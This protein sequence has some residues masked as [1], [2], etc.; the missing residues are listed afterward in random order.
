MSKISKYLSFVKF[1]H[2]V[3]ALPF[4]LVGASVG[5]ITTENSFDYW[6]ILFIVLCMVFARNAAMGF[7]RYVDRYFDSKNPRT[8]QREIPSGKITLKDAKIFI[9]LNCILFIISAL[10]INKMC[11]L[12]S[13]IALIVI[14]GYSITKRFTYLCHFVLGIGLGLAPLGAYIAIM[15]QFELLP[16]LL[17]LAVLFWVSGFDIIYALQDEEFDKANDLH[18]IPAK[19]GKKIGLRISRVSHIFSA[20]FMFLFIGL[21]ISNFVVEM[22]QGMVAFLIFVGSLIYQ[23]SIIRHYNL[24]KVNIA[25]F[26]T[27]GFASILFAIFFIYGV[28]F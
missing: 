23:Q 5:I 18:S 3:F 25:F 27:N 12:L 2:T 6:K 17:G 15:N 22:I 20:L 14:L 11:F 24:N 26:T 28:F 10:L 16:I 21:S 1:S 7:N 19:F 8:A 9:L 13:P 4:A